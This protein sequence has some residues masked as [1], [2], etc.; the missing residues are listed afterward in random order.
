MRKLPIYILVDSSESMIGEA[1]DAAQKG[2]EIILSTLRN[3]PYALGVAAVS[4]ISFNGKASV[5]TPMTEISRFKKSDLARIQLGSGSALGAAFDLLADRIRI[6]VVKTSE[7][8]KG[9]WKPFVFILTDVAPTDDWSA[10]FKRLRAIKFSRILIHRCGN[11]STKDLK[12][13]LEYRIDDILGFSMSYASDYEYLDEL[14][15]N[16]DKDV[17]D[18]PPL[19]PGITLIQP[20]SLQNSTSEKTSSRSDDAPPIIQDRERSLDELARNLFLHALCAVKGK[21]SLVRFTL[22]KET[23]RYTEAK[24]YPLPDDF[25]DSC[26]GSDVPRVSS[27]LLRASIPP[28][29][30]CGN[31]WLICGKCGSFYCDPMK[32]NSTSICPR[33]GTKGFVSY[34]GAAID[35]VAEDSSGIAYGRLPYGGAEVDVGTSMG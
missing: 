3:D 35:V 1:F 22:D 18:I 26:V 8:Q 20:C 7:T 27:H 29:P 6:E 32:P 28:C 2:I 23:R 4:I 31:D 13:I 21:K 10:A 24:L 5:I 25:D 16:D 15:D 33:C 12:A 30:Y 19:P 11:D 17:D 34:N 14:N 9:D